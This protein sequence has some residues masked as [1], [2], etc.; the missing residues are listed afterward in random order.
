MAEETPKK[1]NTNFDWLSLAIQTLLVI[2]G[3]FAGLW[4][5]EWHSNTQSRHDAAE[6]GKRLRLEIENNLKLAT[7]SRDYH[8]GLVTKLREGDF[9]DSDKYPDISLFQR[10]FISPA[11]LT[12]SAWDAAQTTQ[13]TQFMPYEDILLFS[14]IYSEQERYESQSA[15]AGAALFSELLNHGQQGLC[16]KWRNLADIIATFAYREEQLVRRYQQ[17]LEEISKEPPP[18]R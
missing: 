12:N 16:Q 13:L 10:G 7:T 2:F 17:I 14:D 9:N 11:L 4:V 8:R 6:A 15:L 3:V 18:V 1:K 5:N